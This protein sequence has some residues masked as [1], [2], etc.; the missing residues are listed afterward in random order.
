VFNL[1]FLETA[2]NTYVDHQGRHKLFDSETDLVYPPDEKRFRET[3]LKS[4]DDASEFLQALEQIFRPLVS[5]P[6]T[7]EE[8]LKLFVRAGRT[9]FEYLRKGKR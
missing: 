8:Q 4:I 3:L 6:E 2:I 9:D 5:I 7:R 1:F